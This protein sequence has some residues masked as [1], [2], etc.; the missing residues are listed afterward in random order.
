MVQQD[1]LNRTKTNHKFLE[2]TTENT[3]NLNTGG[4]CLIFDVLDELK[5]A[6]KNDREIQERILTSIKPDILLTKT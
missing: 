1:W 2:L 3:A 5:A 6:F 4:D